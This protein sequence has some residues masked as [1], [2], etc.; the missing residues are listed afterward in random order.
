MTE[1]QTGSAAI[2]DIYDERQRQIDVEGFDFARDDKYTDWSL[3]R[4]AACYCLAVSRSSKIIWQFWPSSW[5]WNWFKHN[6]AN[7]RRSLVKAGALIVAEIERLDRAEDRSK[8][9]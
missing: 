1:M 6:S 2:Q 5:D 8:T 7:P 9:P 4:V 3:S